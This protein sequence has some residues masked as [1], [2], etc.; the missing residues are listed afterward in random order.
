MSLESNEN[1][2]RPREVVIHR[3]NGTDS[4]R[5]RPRDLEGVPRASIT[6]P[7]GGSTVDSQART[8]INSIISTLEALGLIDNN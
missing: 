5:I 8:A 6:A 1:T 4:P 2:L 3:H 7:S